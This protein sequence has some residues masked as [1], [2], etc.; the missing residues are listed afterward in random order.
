MYRISKGSTHRRGWQKYAPILNTKQKQTL[1]NQKAPNRTRSPQLLKLVFISFQG[2]AEGPASP[3]CCLVLPSGR[4]STTSRSL[5]KS[6][7][8][9]ASKS[10]NLRRC[11]VNQPRGWLDNALCKRGIVVREIDLWQLST[12]Q[13]AQAVSVHPPPS[14]ESYKSRN[15]TPHVSLPS[16]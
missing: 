13:N 6:N 5:Q 2:E 1:C 16:F 4:T 7:E 3:S 11:T 14:E 12:W 9:P 15:A 8:P 10:P